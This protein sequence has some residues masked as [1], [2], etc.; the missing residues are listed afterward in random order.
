[1]E[2]AIK[3]DNENIVRL[4]I[5]SGADVKAVK[6]NKRTPLHLAASWSKNV[7]ISKLLIDAGSYINAKNTL[8]ET[9]L[10]WCIK[11]K[12]VQVFKFL[13]DSGAKVNE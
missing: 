3:T 1:M 4:L 5:E 2:L 8:F 6:K 13:I 11:S 12:N 9:P 7:Q 10:H